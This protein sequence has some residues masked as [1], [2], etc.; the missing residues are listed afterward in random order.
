MT[1]QVISDIFNFFRPFSCGGTESF[2]VVFVGYIAMLTSN[3]AIA[4]YK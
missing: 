3:V 2:G 1:L 4:S